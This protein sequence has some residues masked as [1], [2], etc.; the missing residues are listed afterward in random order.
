[1]PRLGGDA[2]GVEAQIVD[3][4]LA[5]GS[6]Q[7][8]GSIDHARLAF[9]RDVNANAAAEALDALDDPVLDE[10]TPSAR[11]ASTARRELGILVAERTCLLDDGDTAAEALISLRQL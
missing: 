8:M 7:Q 9:A 6:E 10:S 4:G 2:G 3:I 5:P 1:M 11:S